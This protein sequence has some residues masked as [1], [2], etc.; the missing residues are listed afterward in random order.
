VPGISA[1]RPAVVCLGRGRLADIPASARCFPYL[2]LLLGVFG[3]RYQ[4][5]MANLLKTVQ[6]RSGWC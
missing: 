4:I 3:E 1:H 2:A 5:M 6:A